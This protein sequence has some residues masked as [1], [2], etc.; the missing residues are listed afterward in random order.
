MREKLVFEKDLVLYV[1]ELQALSSQL[2][3]TIT[4]L[5]LQTPCLV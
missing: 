1:C 2:L 5:G 4:C 3:E